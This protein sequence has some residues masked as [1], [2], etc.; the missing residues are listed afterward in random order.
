MKRIRGCLCYRWRFGHF[1]RRTVLDRPDLLTNPRAIHI[2]RCVEIRKG[3][4]LEAVGPW[5]G[6]TPKLVIGDGTV[7]HLYFHCGA[8]Q[9]V[10]IGRDVLIAGRVYISDHDH[11]FDDPVLPAR[12]ASG[13]RSAPVVIEDGVWLGEGCVILKGVRVGQR[14]VVGA[15]AVVT[16]DVPPFT[17][18]GGVPARVIRKIDVEVPEPVR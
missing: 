18:V 15:N 11:V 6:K 9:S 13:L 1:G 17:I 5:D 14:A 4:R 10:T 3:S 16:K 12:R 7:I 8:A 2:G